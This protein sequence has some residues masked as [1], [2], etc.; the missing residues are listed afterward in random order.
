MIHAYKKYLKTLA[1]SLVQPDVTKVP[2]KQSGLESTFFDEHQGVVLPFS[3]QHS[4]SIVMDLEDFFIL[5]PDYCQKYF[6]DLYAAYPFHSL[7]NIFAHR[8]A[9]RSW[10]LYVPAGARSDDLSLV[11]NESACREHITIIVAQGAY[12]RIHERMGAHTGKRIK[13]V[14]IILEQNAYLEF[15]VEQKDAPAVSAY[16][17]YRCF[18]YENAQF[19]GTFLQQG[20]PVRAM[21]FELAMLGRGAHAHL[22]GLSLIERTH[23]AVFV[24]AQMHKAEHTHSSVVAKS[25]VADSAQSVYYG[26]ITIEKHAAG[27]EAYQQNKNIVLGSAA[28]VFSQPNLE[29]NTHT[30]RC[31]H[32]SATGTFD[33]DELLYMQSRGVQPESARML[34]CKAFMQDVTHTALGTLTIPA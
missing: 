14:D 11:L 29:I 21:F 4:T 27:T 24:T 5:Y 23:Q 3:V 6:F 16:V 2:W 33:L 13:N 1:R 7:W 34:L 8:Y 19:F 26:T 12:A 15:V 30:V 18:A 9:E 28:H 22:K 25:L 10:V 20:G 31:K 32:G 17:Q